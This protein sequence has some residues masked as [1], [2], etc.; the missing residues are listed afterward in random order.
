VFPQVS[1]LA[2]GSPGGPTGG[3]AARTL[4]SQA[5]ANG[6][7]TSAAITLADLNYAK[8]TN[9]NASLPAIATNMK[10]GVLRYNGF[11][12]NFIYANPQ[13][14]NAQ[15]ISNANHANY[16]SMQLQIVVRPTRGFS[17]TASYTWAK[18][19]GDGPGTDPTERALDYTYL[20]NSRTHQLISYGTFE[21]PFGANG[22]F[23]R[24]V[25]SPV[26]KRVMEGWTVGWILALQSGKYS[27]LDS[28]V[29]HLY[30]NPVP[31]YVA[32]EG[33]F[34]M[35][36][37]RGDFPAG[38]RSGN[39]FGNRL[40]TVQDPLC[41][42][43][44]FVAKELA[45]SCTALSL[46]L[47]GPDGKATDQYVFRQPLPGQ[48][49]N[50][51]LNT[52]VGPGMFSLDMNMGK[53]VQLTEGKT[54]SIRFDAQNVLNHPTPSNGYSSW[55]PRF[56]QVYEPNFQISSTTPFGYIATKAGHRTFQAK[57]RISF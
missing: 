18:G 20:S 15:W 21:L 50:I 33:V 48:R 14:L 8:S 10:G 4:F 53:S 36:S 32:Q 31:N 2:V 35:K 54:F 42:D 3:K 44:Q 5:L 38:A 40:I 17:S 46:A 25:T 23:F 13:L 26:V 9:V 12:E 39:Y 30:G 22:F 52:L 49:G 7:Y 57:A 11:P 45:S 29:F 6:D 19:L 56:T 1:S 43:E 55:N 16:H 28:G 41:K 51:G 24:N 34:D 47:A 27:N 37:G